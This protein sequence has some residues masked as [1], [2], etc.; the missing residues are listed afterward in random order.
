M[1]INRSNDDVNVWRM[2]G[3][4]S[5]E[6]RSSSGR[7]NSLL[8]PNCCNLARRSLAQPSHCSRIGCPIKKSA[9]KTA[10]ARHIAADF[11]NHE[12]VRHSKF[13]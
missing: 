5:D 13:F 4:L 11:R 1:E 10:S 3:G 6:G 9:S 7:W 8:S 2:S 12:Y